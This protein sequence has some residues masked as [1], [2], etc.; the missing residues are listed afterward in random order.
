MKIQTKTKF[1]SYLKIVPKNFNKQEIYKYNITLLN[2]TV[3]YTQLP[4]A[5]K[6]MKYAVITI[7]YTRT[8]LTNTMLLDSTRLLLSYEMRRIAN[9]IMEIVPR[10]P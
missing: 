4:E 9:S 10:Q 8:H 3:S 2:V 5:A 1:Y 7:L 6:N